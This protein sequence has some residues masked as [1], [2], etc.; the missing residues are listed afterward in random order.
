[1]V[2]RGHEVSTYLFVTEYCTLSPS[3]QAFVQRHA[4]NL[5]SA[6]TIPLYKGEMQRAGH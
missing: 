2:L 5:D 4:N 1:V 6:A 3:I